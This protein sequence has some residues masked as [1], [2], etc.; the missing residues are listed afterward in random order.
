MSTFTLIEINGDRLGDLQDD[1]N[2]DMAIKLSAIA[3]CVRNPSNA[4]RLLEEYGLDR[5]IRFVHQ[6]GERYERPR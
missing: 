1:T 5:V 2:I 6:S 4:P 3:E